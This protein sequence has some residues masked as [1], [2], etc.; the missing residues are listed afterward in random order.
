M[1]NLAPPW[2]VRHAR[3]SSR[4]VRRIRDAQRED[5]GPGSWTAGR[6]RR[7]RRVTPFLPPK[8]PIREC[9]RRSAAPNPV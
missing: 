1:R 9:R 4:F 6:D 5:E 7:P 2:P 3:P 8:A